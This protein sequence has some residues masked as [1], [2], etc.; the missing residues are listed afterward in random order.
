MGR[1]ET[2]KKLYV[3]AQKMTIGMA[4]MVV[5]YGA[6]GYFLIR[7]GKAGSFVLGTQIYPFVKYGALAV[8]VFGVFMMGKLGHRAIDSFP[9]EVPVTERPPQKLFVRTVLMNAG[10]QLSLLVGL[11]LIFFGRRP[12]D[13]IPF[14]V[15]SLAGFAL[16]FP[17]KQQWVAWL[18]ADF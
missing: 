1:M 4:V 12:F 17:K 16:A 14:A 15:L 7:T 6:M 3:Q 9:A 11:L 13:F 18:G 8:S 5:A 2:A 10:G